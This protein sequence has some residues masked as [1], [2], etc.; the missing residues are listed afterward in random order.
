MPWFFRL[1]LLLIWPRAG[2]G[3]AE[4]QALVLENLALRQQLAVL[5]RA[6]RRPRL[7]GGDRAFWV[8]L[9]RHWLA[10]KEVCL[11]V[12]PGTVV[13]WHRAGFRLFWAWKS[14]RP[15]GRPEIASNVRVLIRKMAEE[16]PLWGAPRIHGELLMLGLVVSERTV[17]RWMPR[18]PPDQR[19]AQTWRTFLENHKDVLA[20]MDFLVV[21]TWNFRQLYVLV[22]LEHGRRVIRHLNV[23]TNPTAAWVKQQLREAFPYD[24]VP[25]YLLFD[26]DAT[27]GAVKGFVATMGITPKQTS[28]RS[29]WQNGHSERV[30]GT[31]R[32]D[33][34]DHVV[35][36]NEDHLRRMLKGYL[37]YY[38]QDRTHLGLGKDS[39][40]GRPMDHAPG[41]RG[42]IVAERRCGGL[43]HR[44]RWGQLA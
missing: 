9:S 17:S 6:G 27:F 7:A 32:R 37:S 21:P 30:I 4:V 33:L 10:W 26:R 20:A 25:R 44:Y 5:A 19:R 41:A 39:P 34:L 22:V 11:L 12:K 36:L 15:G 23:T 18:R 1:L 2:K 16:N 14:R 24:E 38:H 42:Q 29:P 43:H 3:S 35:A 31:L 28:P 13:R 8:L 40:R